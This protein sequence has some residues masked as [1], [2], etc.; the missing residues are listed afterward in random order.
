MNRLTE[1]DPIVSNSNI[2]DCRCGMCKKLLRE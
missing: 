2:A 1:D